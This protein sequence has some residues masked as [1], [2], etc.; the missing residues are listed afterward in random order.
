MKLFVFFLSIFLFLSCSLTQSQQNNLFNPGEIWPD[1][2][3][4]HINAHGG[5][6]IFH[7]G[8]YYWYG[9]HKSER[10]NSAQVGI[11]CY[12]SDDLYNWTN[13]GVALPVSDDPQSDIVKGSVMERPKVLYNEK[14]GKFVMWFH[15]ELKGKGYEAARAAVAVS[16]SP[17]GTFTYLHSLR[18]NA[19]KWPLNM[20]QEH[21]DLKETLADYPKWWT[22]EWYEAIHKGLLVRRDLE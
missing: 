15:L 21:R 10:T 12:S 1:N 6:I 16:D 19:G 5:G 3:G 4:V 17:T 13:E 2:N 8:K 9:E 20:P 18:P 7:N 14:T 22:P 11:M